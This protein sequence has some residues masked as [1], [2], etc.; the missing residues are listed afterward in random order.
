MN[1]RTECGRSAFVDA[2]MPPKTTTIII[3]AIIAILASGARNSDRNA[4][5]AAA[6]AC[7][8][9]QGKRHS[10]SSGLFESGAAGLGVGALRSLVLNCPV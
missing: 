4:A 10:I 6:E 7:S 9:T 8:E 3:G 1:G 2:K 5:V